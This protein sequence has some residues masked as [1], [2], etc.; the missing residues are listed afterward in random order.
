M[1]PLLADHV[2]REAE[3]FLEILD[4]IQGDMTD[5]DQPPIMHCDYE[6]RKK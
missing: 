1:P 5:C 2:R 4:M 6:L 3:Y